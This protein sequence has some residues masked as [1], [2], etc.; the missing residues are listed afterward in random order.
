MRK[1]KHRSFDSLRSLR[2]TIKN[3]ELSADARADGGNGLPATAQI[4][5]HWSKRTQ[6]ENAPGSAPTIRFCNPSS[7]SGSAW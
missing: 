7:G 2:T 4:L 3:W 1:S 6:G 5:L